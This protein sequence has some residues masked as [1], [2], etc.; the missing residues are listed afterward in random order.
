M[1][2]NRTPIPNPAHQPNSN[3][4]EV[5]AAIIDMRRSLQEAGRD[6]GPQTI[7]AHLER[8]HGTGPAVSTIW[9][10]LTG[11]GL[12]VAEPKKR[13]R[14]SYLRFQAELPNETWQSDFTH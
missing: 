3:P 1:G 14:S 9:K 8:D 11:H 5:E 6:A 7:A 10:V 2:G 4:P 13:L 12:V